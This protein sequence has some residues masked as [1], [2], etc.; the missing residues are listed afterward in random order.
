MSAKERQQ[1]SW[2]EK[3]RAHYPAI[4]SF[5]DQTMGGFWYPERGADLS[6]VYSD[7]HQPPPRGTACY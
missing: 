1:T 6:S 7:T 3:C 5:D 2:S 4:G